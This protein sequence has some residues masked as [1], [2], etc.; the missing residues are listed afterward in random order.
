MANYRLTLSFN[1]KNYKSMGGVMKKIINGALISSQI[2]EEIKKEIDK[3]EKKPCLATII[4]GN[5]PASHIY[6]KN[7]G[8]ACEYVG[9]RSKKYILPEET[10]QNEL[11]QII[12]K[13]NNDHDINGILVQL[14]LPKHINQTEVILKID[15]KKDVDAF[16]PYNTGLILADEGKVFPCTPAGCI[17]LLKRKNIEIESK[18]CLVIGRS[19]IVGKPLALMLIK[20]N[21]TVTIANSKTKNLKELAN[22]ADIIFIAIGKAK[23]LNENMI[24][25]GAIIIDIGINRLENGKICGDCDF[26]KCY[27]KAGFITPVPGG[28]G[29]MT[30]AMLLK[31]CLNAYKIQNN[32]LD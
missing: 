23:F 25:E 8:I 22:S 32:I 29:P 11:L 27:D 12:D 31:N 19:N 9:I 28:V 5:D 10:S 3:F 16:H 30:I 18:N 17:E 15:P 6:V 24:K 13:L 1:I 14:P 21:A 4:L 7:K 2:K 26:E 20:E